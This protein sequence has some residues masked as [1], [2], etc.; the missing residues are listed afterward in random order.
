MDP[1]RALMA[2]VDDALKLFFT[3]PTGFR[4][5]VSIKWY[6]PQRGGD[7]PSSAPPAIVTA[8]HGSHAVRDTAKMDFYRGTAVHDLSNREWEDRAVR[9]HY[10]MELMRYANIG[11]TASRGNWMETLAG[12]AFHVYTHNIEIQA[13]GGGH[14]IINPPEAKNLFRQI[15]PKLEASGV[16]NPWK[17][18]TYERYWI[19]RQDEPM[20]IQPISMQMH[21]METPE[22]FYSWQATLEEDEKKAAKN[23]AWAQAHKH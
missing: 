20:E 2:E 7:T 23:R 21:N 22:L 15:W 12:A 3:Y 11:S 16:P 14:V 17:D 9:M 18:P 19:P 1:L 13:R 6:H 4:E 5:P 10:G 8:A